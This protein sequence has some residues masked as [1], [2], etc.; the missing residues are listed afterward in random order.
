MHDRHLIAALS[1][2]SSALLALL[3]LASSVEHS[4]A[5]A[6]PIVT[7]VSQRS[8]PV[9][10][11]WSSS[12][13]AELLVSGYGLAATY[14]GAPPPACRITPAAGES[15]FVH[16][17]GYIDDPRSVIEVNATVVSGGSPSCSPPCY[18]APNNRPCC[19]SVLRCEPPP[20]VLAPG[21]GTLS[22]RN[23]VGW[24]VEQQPVEY[25]LRV[26]YLCSVHI[27]MYIQLLHTNLPYRLQ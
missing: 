24:S 5:F 9:E 7:A 22:V 18:H 3:P 20:G 16:V 10:G 6:V 25:L 21:P 2:L 19:K 14:A 17:S 27:D 26:V 8:F 1:M 11:P 13:R 12:N 4:R 23:N 15:A